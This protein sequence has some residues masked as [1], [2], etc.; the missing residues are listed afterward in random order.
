MFSDRETAYINSQRLVRLATVSNR[1]QPDVVPVSFEFDGRYFWIGSR[2]QE[3]FLV[4]KRYK[5][6]SAGND[7][8]AL[9]IDDLESVNPWKAHQ[10]KVYGIGEVIDHDGRLG[11]GKYLRVTPK[12]SWSLGIETDISG[13][14]N[15]QEMLTNWRTRRIHRVDG[16]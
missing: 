11:S 15:P 5:N 1:G 12:I 3:I 10:I 8:V 2:P 9:V 16:Q 13:Y 4:T 7:R 6:V 14:N